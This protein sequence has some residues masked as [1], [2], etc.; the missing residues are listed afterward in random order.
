MS[1]PP[2]ILV[3]SEIGNAFLSLVLVIVIATLFLSFTALGWI[4]F[5]GPLDLLTPY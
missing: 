1:K 5:I 2:D 4:W 3:E